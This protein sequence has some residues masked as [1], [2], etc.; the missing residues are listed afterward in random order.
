M[1]Q[2]NIPV[3]E[4]LT[5][6]NSLAKYAPGMTNSKIIKLDMFRGMR[7]NIA[8]NVMMRDNLPKTFSE[9]LDQVLRSKTIRQC[10]AKDKKLSKEPTPPALVQR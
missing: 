4:F 9:A 8:K 10:M 6:L 2:R 7:S 3:K 5:K 1:R